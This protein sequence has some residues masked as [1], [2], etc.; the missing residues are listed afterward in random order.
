MSA[1]G[2]RRPKRQSIVVALHP[3]VFDRHVLSVD[4][5]SFVQAPVARGDTR[6]K[7]AR[8]CAALD[9]RMPR[10]PAHMRRPVVEGRTCI[11]VRAWQ[12]A[13]LLRPGQ[14]FRFSWSRR[15]EPADEVMPMNAAVVLLFPWRASDTAMWK[16][17][18]QHVP[19]TSTPCHFGGTRPW[20]LCRS[21]RA[22]ASAAT[23][24][25]R[26]TSAAMYSATVG[27]VG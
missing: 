14:M 19:L 20:F 25:S 22:V 17:V 16:P 26:C 10:V 6:F 15:A 13:G 4:I 24:A 27:A 5:A 18:S 11:D 9:R 12:R 2:R 1:C 7:R 8:R 21:V 3:A 23:D